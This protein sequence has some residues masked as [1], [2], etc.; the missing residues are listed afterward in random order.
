M[1][2]SEIGHAQQVQDDQSRSDDVTDVK[3]RSCK[4][5]RTSYDV[6]DK[7]YQ[8]RSDEIYDVKIIIIQDQENI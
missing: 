4:I 8:T 1:D 3:M 5:K 7:I 6:Y 2:W